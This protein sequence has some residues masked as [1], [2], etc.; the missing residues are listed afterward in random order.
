[1]VN[2]SNLVKH[3]DKYFKENEY[4]PYNG[5]VFDISKETGNRTLQFGMI[6][7]FKN[8]SYK[9]WYSNGKP[10]TT[11]QYFN[12]DSTNSWAKWYENGQKKFEIHYKNDQLNGKYGYWYENGQ[13]EI[14][15]TYKDGKKDK[16]WTKWYENGQKEIESSF[17]NG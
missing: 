7:G 5:I 6:D 1:M 10:K 3:G 13:K 11:G 16:S 8:G 4:I 15:G 14:E 17:K 12:D 2:V 9:E